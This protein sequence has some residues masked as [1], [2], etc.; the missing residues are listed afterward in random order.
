[1]GQERLKCR[2]GDESDPERSC[3]VGEATPY[4]VDRKL[5]LARQQSRVAVCLLAAV[6]ATGGSLAAI[7][8]HGGATSMSAYDFAGQGNCQPGRPLWA[9]ESPFNKCRE[10]CDSATACIGFDWDAQWLFCRV[11]FASNAAMVSEP[12]PTGS[13][14]FVGIEGGRVAGEVASSILDAKKSHGVR[15]YQKVHSLPFL[16]YLASP[17]FD[18][19]GAAW[20]GPLPN[21]L[22]Y[23]HEAGLAGL[24]HR[25]S[26]HVTLDKAS[27]AL[28][29]AGPMQDMVMPSLDA[30]PLLRALSQASL[31][32]VTVVAQLN[33]N[34]DCF[35]LTLEASPMLNRTGWRDSSARS[36]V[37]LRPSAKQPFVVM[38]DGRPD[39][40]QGKVPFSLPSWTVSG[41]R[42]H[43]LTMTFGRDGYNHVMLAPAS[44][45]SQ[46]STASL[47]WRQ[48]L[49]D[50]R[51]IPSVYAITHC[52]GSQTGK[53]LVG[54]IRIRC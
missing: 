31:P 8:R 50:G 1:M 48:M 6:V 49:F 38:N 53:V 27:G 18:K 32:T 39:L 44:S 54:Q 19:Q 47:S 40:V 21:I 35:G 42:F 13:Q 9:M 33:S 11:L 52:H 37:I 17:T 36:S 24:L 41:A 23:Y 2:D 3:L 22:D 12:L 28:A 5:H 20:V 30:S 7:A 14:R 45:L 29:F 34:S 26:Q 10:T 16:N 51:D 43:T 15:C 4:V 46:P 25:A